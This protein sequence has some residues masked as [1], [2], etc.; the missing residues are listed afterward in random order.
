MLLL[1]SAG[2]GENEPRTREAICNLVMESLGVKIKNELNYT[3]HGKECLISTPDSKVKVAIIPTDE[4]VMIARDA[5]NLCL[6]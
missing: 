1:F 4:E 3:I 5:Y 6:K 2:I